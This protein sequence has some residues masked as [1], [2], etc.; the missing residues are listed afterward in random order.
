VKKAILL[1]LLFVLGFMAGTL[2]RFPVT[3]AATAEPK[4]T[5]VSSSDMY[6]HLQAIP[7]FPGI[8]YR[9]LVETATTGVYADEISSSGVALHR[10]LHSREFM[11]VVSGTGT[12]RIGGI[13]ANVGPGDFFVI[14]KAVPHSLRG[15]AGALRVLEVDD[16]PIG[17]NDVHLVQ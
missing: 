15:G 11:Y 1:S 14:P 9:T 3:L 8:R 2:S 16:P 12:V 5:V 7:G 13:S 4:A 17:P 6:T 10:H